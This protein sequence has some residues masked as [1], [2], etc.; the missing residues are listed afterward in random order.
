MDLQLQHLL[1]ARRQHFLA[2]MVGAPRS[3]APAPPWRHRRFLALMV[4]ALGSSA[5]TPFGGPSLTFLSVDGGRFW[6][7]SSGTSQVTRR[8]HFFSSSTY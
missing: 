5:L 7:F 3:S 1:G 2:L 4:S 8:R 6:I